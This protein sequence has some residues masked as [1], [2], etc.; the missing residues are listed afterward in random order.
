[1][2]R[3]PS[4][5]K[6]IFTIVKLFL[7]KRTLEKFRTCRGDIANGNIADCPYVRSHF[8]IEH[9]PSYLG[10]NCNCEGGCVPGI[11]NDI[12]KQK[13]LPRVPTDAE[14]E[15]IAKMVLEH[16]EKEEQELAEYLKGQ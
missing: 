6:W 11:P 4:W 10:G 8:A 16:R 15:M 7:S 5:F 9:V 14:V 1:M 2:I 13:D 12:E 3:T